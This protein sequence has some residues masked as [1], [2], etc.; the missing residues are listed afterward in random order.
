M[1]DIHLGR[2]I[3]P[4][5][6]VDA[7]EQALRLIEQAV[8]AVQGP[9]TDGIPTLSIVVPVYNER[10]TLPIVLD[11]ID[12]IE[13]DKQTVVVD[14]GSRDGTA[15]WLAS[16]PARRDRV[17]ILRRRNRGKGASLRIGFRHTRGHVVAIQDADLEY[18]PADLVRVI[19]PIL[20][21]LAD[22]VYGSR[23]LGPVVQDTSRLHRAGNRLLTGLSN[24]LTGLH[25]SD[26]ET[27][28]KAFRGELIRS[29]PIRE[30]RF[31]FEPEIT[32]RVARSGAR[33]LE[34]PTRY[35]SRGYDEGKKIG[36][37]DAAVALWCM[38]RYSRWD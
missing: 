35:D 38:A 9:L 33:L 30:N 7:A 31:G 6:A 8:E 29:L 2:P 18:D 36:W 23:Y 13:I 14:D 32:A 19:Q 10:Q 24:R 21:G 4:D 5:A 27:C 34:V 25:L 16:L 1:T 15:D 12:R 11:R 22:V 37:R 26:M 20:A 28:H 3:V 17:V